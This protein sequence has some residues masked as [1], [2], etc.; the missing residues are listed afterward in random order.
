MLSNWI[1]PPRNCYKINVDGAVFVAHKMA[2][3]GILI[4]DANG[5]VI[6]AC[7]KKIMAPLGATEAEATTFEIGL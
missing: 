5:K 6:E 4:R 2:S 7:S 1:P 3:V